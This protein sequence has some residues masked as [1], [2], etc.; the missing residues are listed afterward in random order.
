MNDLG[1]LK[2]LNVDS[3]NWALSR[4]LAGKKEA[5]AYVELYNKTRASQATLIEKSCFAGSGQNVYDFV[6]LFILVK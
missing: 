1:N 3:A 4:G 6:Y 5:E 2:E